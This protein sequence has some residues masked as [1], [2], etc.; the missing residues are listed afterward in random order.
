VK[1]VTAIALGIIAALGGFL[2][3]GELVFNTQAG[4]RFGYEVLWAVPIGVVGIIVYSEMAGRV[5]AI[6]KQATFDLIRRRYSRRLGLV[7]LVGSTLLNFLTL[8]AEVGGVGLALQL[9]FD[10]SPQAF[11]LLAVV[12]LLAAAWLLPFEGLERVFGYGGLG[13]LVYAVA[14]FDLGP[15]WSAVGD[16]FVP[17][18]RSSSLYWY[19]IVGMIAAALMPYE[20]YF[21]SSGGIEEG[22]TEENLAENRLNAIVG[23]TL[24]G[25]LSAALVVA[26]AQ[27]LLPNGVSPDSLGGV[28]LG[29]QHTYGELA[30]VLA[31]LGIFFAVGGAAID[32]GFSAAYNLAQYLGWP[33]GKQHGPREAPR[34][35]VTWT[36]LFVAGYAV[37]STGVNPVSLTEYAVV[38][39]AAVLP[40]TYLPLLRASRDPQLMGEHASGPLAGA[41]GLIYLG[42]ICVVS[43]AAPV[44]LVVTRGGQG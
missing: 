1:R 12:I 15:D 19:F 4:A 44:L 39:S 17:E 10:V 36:G 27:V 20:I 7:T 23:F 13:L 41:L 35:Y 29:I 25:V 28:V 8:A 22:W 33:W 30:L 26:A 18:A 21:Y 2:D 38:L 6:G 9:I 42:V 43:V 16:G 3:I 37:V 14:S 32:A 11:M 40:L 34:W 31:L 24:G 5:A